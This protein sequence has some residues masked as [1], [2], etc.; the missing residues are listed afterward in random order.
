LANIV[1]IQ[2]RFHGPEPDWA[3]VEFLKDLFFVGF[4]EPG[5][6]TSGG[7]DHGESWHL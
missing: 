3:S 7:Q 6:L 5:G 2:K 1:T 4:A